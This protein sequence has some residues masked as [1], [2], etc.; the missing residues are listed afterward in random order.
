MRNDVIKHRCRAASGG[1]ERDT[2]GI[3][4]RDLTKPIRL[5]VATLARVG[6]EEGWIL[7]SADT[8]QRK[9][10]AE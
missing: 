10:G 1:C 8:E 9:A 4:K 5:D 3:L 2:A 6:S 7:W